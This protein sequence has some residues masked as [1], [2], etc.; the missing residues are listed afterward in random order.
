MIARCLRDYAASERQKQ[1]DR[2][3]GTETD[4]DRNLQAHLGCRPRRW[5][6]TK[7]RKRTRWTGGRVGWGVF[8]A[9]AV[10]EVHVTLS[11]RI[12]HAERE[13]ET[14]VRI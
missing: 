11:A 13:D 9:K 1:T 8:K 12:R 6:S 7:H 3:T 5:V 14:G 10:K 4:R 2:E